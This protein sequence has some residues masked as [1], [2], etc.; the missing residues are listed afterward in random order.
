[1]ANT[2]PNCKYCGRFLNPAH[3]S[4]EGER[5]YDTVELEPIEDVFWHKGCKKR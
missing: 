2:L 1:M 3:K 4:V 5:V